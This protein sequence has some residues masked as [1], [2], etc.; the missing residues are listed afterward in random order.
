MSSPAPS[1]SFKVA[2][3]GAGAIAATHLAAIAQ[4][5]GVQLVGICDLDQKK[6]KELAAQT[7]ISAVFTDLAAMLATAKPDIVHILLPPTA[8]AAT[9]ERCL[10]AGC[11]VFVEKP[12]C[13]TVEQCQQLERVAAESGRSIGVNHNLTF[14]PAMASL[15]EVLRSGRLG[16]IEHVSVHYTLPFPGLGSFTPPGW[17]FSAPGLLMLELGPHPVSVLCRLLGKALEVKAVATSPVT[18]PNGVVLHR[19]WS[20]VLEHE[21]GTS[22][23]YLSLGSDNYGA[24][25]HIAGQDGEGFADLRRN[26]VVISEKSRFLRLN[27]YMD[28]MGRALQLA[29]RAH[30]NLL[31]WARG[32]L[33][34]EP[35]YLLQIISVQQSLLAFYGALAQGQSPRIDGAEGTAVV[36][37]CQL[38]INSALAPNQ[39]APQHAR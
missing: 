38:I 12:F 8:H 22:S 14:M 24:S 17:M 33:G 35:P 25:V 1:F 21:R 36:H 11:H 30:A 7:G 16:A 31:R 2:F 5:P 3:L 39:E 4:I 13:V 20:A 26:T 18:L 27:D 19:S 10:R 9:A 23:M 15:I 29:R 32:I 34:F 28:T 6:A 37:A